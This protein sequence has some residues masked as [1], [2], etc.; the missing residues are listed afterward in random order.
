MSLADVIVRAGWDS[1]SLDSGIKSSQ[2]RLKDF[3]KTAKETSVSFAASMRGLGAAIATLGVASQIGEMIK[4]ADAYKNMSAQLSLVSKST[5]DLASAQKALFEIAQRTRSG[6]EP[7]VKLFASLGRSTETLGVSQRDLLTVTETIN[8]ALLVSGANSASAEAALIQLGQ[9]MASGTLR[10]EELNSVM[11]Q[12]PRLAKAIADGM[13][14]TI[15]QLRQLGQDGK[16]TGEA[17]FNALKGQFDAINTEFAKLP[18]TVGGSLTVLGNAAGQAVANLDKATGATAKLAAG[19][20]FLGTNIDT[21][22]PVIGTAIAYAGVR[23]TASL[24]AS[25]VAAAAASPA[26][27][28][29]AASVALIGPASATAIA[30]AGLMRGALVS[31]TAAGRGLVALLGGP[32]GIAFTA[33]AGVAYL[34]ATN[35]GEADRKNRELVSSLGG[36]K[37][38]LDAYEEAALAAAT[39]TGDA[40]VKAQQHAEALRQ[41]AGAA[42]VAARALR[43]KAV[44]AANAALA[45]EQEKFA[46]STSGG[47]K[48]QATVALEGGQYAQAQVSLKAARERAAAATQAATAAEARYKDILSGSTPA[49]RAVTEATHVSAAADDKKAKSAKAAASAQD[50]F[51]QKLK[52]ARESLE[53]D[54]ERTLRETRET[55]LVF[56]EAFQK[57]KISAAEFREAIERL[58]KPVVKAS[59]AVDVLRDDITPT[60]EAMDDF[61]RQLADCITPAE[62]LAQALGN[63]S[64]AVGSLADS[65]RRGDVAGMAY[66]LQSL[67]TGVAGAFRSGG[68]AGGAT[69]IGSIAGQVIGG[70]TGRAI[71]TGAGIAGLGAV[72]GGF[73]ASGGLAAGVANGIVGLGGSAALAGGVGTAI[74]SIGAALPMIG[75]VAGGLYALSEIFK[76]PSNHGAGYDLITGQ[77]SGQS[78]TEETEGAVKQVGDAVLQMQALLDSAGITRG[79]GVR[80]LVIGSR[81]P[82]QIYTTSGKTITAAK[83]D[84]EAAAN[85]ALDAMLDGATYVSDTQKQLVESMRAAGKGF[86]EIAV[87]LQDYAAAQ[88]LGTSIADAILQLTDPKQYDLTVLKRAQEERDKQVKAA[89]DA[90]YLTAER[91]GEISD[92]LERLKGLEIDQVM[93]RYANAA[94]EAVDA[95]RGELQRAYDAEAGAIRER[96]SEFEQ[97]AQSLRAFDEKLREAALQGQSL[98]QLRNAFAN[99]S[100][101]A[102]ASDKDALGRFTSIADAFSQASTAQ[103]RDSVENRRNQAR[104]RAAT[105]DALKAAQTQVDLGQAQLDALTQSVA[106]LLDIKTATLSVAQAI[107]QLQA[108]LSAQRG[109]AATAANDDSF[110]AAAYGAVNPDV[111]AEFQR[112]AAGTSAYQQ[113]YAPGLSEDEF[114]AAHYNSAGKDEIADGTRLRGFA[115]GGSWQVGGM[116]GLDSQVVA[117]RASPS[118]HAVVTHEDPFATVSA[119]NGLILRQTRRLDKIERATAF[120]EQWEAI[121][122]PPTRV[123]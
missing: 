114:L 119:T 113:F 11:E 55:M 81:D 76:K 103:A 39:A 107:A 59:D 97:L 64:G 99:V 10:G 36:A 82:T 20:N 35:I 71:G 22:L 100:S 1:S 120:L 96:I 102:A 42:V 61:A 79:D 25:G 48:S 17:V 47:L 49:L 121:G 91:F 40:K 78:R 46:A 53:T 6:V 13:G 108:A 15:G 112:Y 29:Y 2:K 98:A 84:V 93:A 4:I 69:A 109:G 45:A 101:I 88:Q 57:G 58:Q 37:S 30:S 52:A 85:A 44:A 83:G 95:A 115:T 27:R 38:A 60:T 21:V 63:I 3:D 65:F 7:T 56:G 110:D 18:T 73:L 28:A 70:K 33:A 14:V 90:G 104:I 105:Q 12:T 23:L 117:F 118:E 74:M 5:A 8:K 34:L 19:I 66:D 123:G 75:I 80:G 62:A 9:G 72:G 67:G 54:S 116:G 43:D 86:D 87:K 50:E 92:Q 122:M 31:V 68:L 24:A 89:L 51:N 106:A 26:V 94:N 32:W 16:L 41:E 111:V 77:F